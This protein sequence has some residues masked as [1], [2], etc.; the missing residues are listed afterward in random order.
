M[1]FLDSLVEESPSPVA[2]VVDAGQI[3]IKRKQ[4]GFY[5]LL[6][7]AVLAILLL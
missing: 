2:S 5:D 7:L 1:E 4:F 3:V 6:E